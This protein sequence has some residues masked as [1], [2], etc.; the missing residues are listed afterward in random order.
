MSARTSA[1]GVAVALAIAGGVMNAAAGGS[2]SDSD[3]AARE[4]EAALQQY[5]RLQLA[6][7][8]AGLSGFY[9]ADGELLE[10]GM[11]ALRGPAAIRAFL[12]SFGDVRI[13]TASMTCEHVDVWENDAVQWGAYT[14]RAVLP[15]K[16]AMDLKGRFVAQWSRVGGRWLIRR[17]LTQPA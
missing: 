10:P 17:L 3:P 13:E 11:D 8:A 7:D 1:I 5:A 12:E 4:I 15:G 9:T 14:Q 2:V 16:P 6:K